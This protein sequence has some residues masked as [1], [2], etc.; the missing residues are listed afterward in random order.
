MRPFLDPYTE[1]MFSKEHGFA[2]LDNSIQG[3]K[4]MWWDHNLIY[5]SSKA[6][7]ALQVESQ[8]K[9]HYKV[10]KCKMGI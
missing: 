5:F 3:E 10:S 7:K 2:R 9:Y 1:L 4:G 6:W 8:Q